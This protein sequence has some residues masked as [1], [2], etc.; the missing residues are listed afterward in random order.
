MFNAVYFIVHAAPNG[1]PM[2]FIGVAD[3][4]GITFTWNAPPGGLLIDSYTLT[5]M[6]GGSSTPIRVQLNPVLQFTL[7]ELDPS[8]VY[9]CTIFARTTGG[10][11]P[12]SLPIQITTAGIPATL[13]SNPYFLYRCHNITDHLYLTNFFCGFTHT[14]FAITDD[15]YFPFIEL[16]AVY[17]VD[18]VFAEES[19]DGTTGPVPIEPPFPFGSS[20]QSQFYVSLT[21]D[22]HL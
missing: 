10:T 9:T 21:L 4:L 1:A 11:G 22:D 7:A 20:T 3:G 12:E 18:R 2:N 17:G 5:C 8:T 19:D 16:G 15:I 14:D 13:Y 6:Y